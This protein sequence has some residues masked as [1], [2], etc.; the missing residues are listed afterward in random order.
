MFGDVPGQ[1]WKGPA[2]PTAPLSICL[3]TRISPS[4]ET[5]KTTAFKTFPQNRAAERCRVP[6]W[7]ISNFPSGCKSSSN[8]FIHLGGLYH[9]FGQGVVQAISKR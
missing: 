8:L 5:T 4:C 1:E 9:R 6:Y 7:L 2:T 3:N